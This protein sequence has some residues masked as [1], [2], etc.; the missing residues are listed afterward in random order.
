LEIKRPKI[1][2]VSFKFGEI[3]NGSIEKVSFVDGEIVVNVDT[4]FH[5]I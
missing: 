1:S 5:L 3:K 4:K 2:N